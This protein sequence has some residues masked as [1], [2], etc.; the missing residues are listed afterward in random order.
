MIFFGTLVVCA[1]ALVLWTSLDF[2]EC[3]K[4][5]GEIKPSAEHLEKGVPAFV[6]SVPTYRHCVGA[7]V[8]DK[9]AVI[10]AVGTLIIAAFTTVLGLFTIS[11]A[12]STRIAA[13]AAGKSAD[14]VIAIELP[15]IRVNEPESLWKTDGINDDSGG[16]EWNVDNTLLPEFS[17]IYELKFRNLGRTTAAPTKLQLGWEV[18]KVL[19]ARKPR[20][21]WA[22]RCDHGTVIPP[23]VDDAIDIECSGFCIALSGRDRDLI[24]DGKAALWVFGALTYLDFLDTP[25]TRRFCW[26]WGCP[27]GTGMYYFHTEEGVPAQYTKKS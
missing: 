25:R 10:T 2:Q 5:Y 14:A 13:N 3:V 19:S 11:L 23:T 1:F 18:T 21:N 26:K 12:G 9:N 27:D 24:K 6:A 7:Y 17:R 20:Y 15:L 22:R 16:L 8:T 4:S